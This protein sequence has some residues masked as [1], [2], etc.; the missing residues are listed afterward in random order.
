VFAK[1]VLRM[2]IEFLYCIVNMLHNISDSIE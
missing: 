1:K 2:W